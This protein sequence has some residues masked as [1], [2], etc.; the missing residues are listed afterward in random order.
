MSRVAQILWAAIVALLDSI[1]KQ[2]L[3][4]QGAYDPNNHVYTQEDVQEIVEFARERGVRVVAEF[5][6]PGESPSTWG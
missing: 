2:F 6:T 4:L 3:H 5:D 1:L